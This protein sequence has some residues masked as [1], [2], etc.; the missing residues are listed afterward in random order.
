MVGLLSA[1]ARDTRVLVMALG[2]R[3]GEDDTDEADVVLESDDDED[4]SADE[5]L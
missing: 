4:E 5:D 2:L 3:S 1:I